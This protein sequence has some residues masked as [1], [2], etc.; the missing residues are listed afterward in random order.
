VTYPLEQYAVRKGFDQTSSHHCRDGR[1]RAGMLREVVPVCGA[2][3]AANE[4]VFSTPRSTEK[5]SR[6][7]VAGGDF[8]TPCLPGNGREAQVHRNRGGWRYHRNLKTPGPA[9]WQMRK[10]GWSCSTSRPRPVRTWQQQA[11]SGMG[12]DVRGNYVHLAV[13]G[14]GP[15]YLRY[16]RRMRRNWQASARPADVGCLGQRSLRL[17]SRLAERHHGGGCLATDPAE[18]EASVT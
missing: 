11:V 13:G 4:W 10:E 2:T 7:F 17:C 12:L 15:P 5:T 6:L 16:L 3:G 14:D 18:N 8:A 9:T 1:C